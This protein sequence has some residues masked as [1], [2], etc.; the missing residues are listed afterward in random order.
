[1]SELA[2]IPVVDIRIGGP[3]AHAAARP[4]AMEELRAACL[5][6]F[7]AVAQSL[8]PLGDAIAR[9]W[10]ERSASPYTAE[11]TEIARLTRQARR[12]SGQYLL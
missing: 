8:V 4:A 11:V 9:R 5:A 7:P 6:Y 10:L 12:L 3:V 1:M 2:E